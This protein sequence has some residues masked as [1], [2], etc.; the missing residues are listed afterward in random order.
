MQIINTSNY[1]TFLAETYIFFSG[2]EHA[3]QG[4][5]QYFPIRS[6]FFQVIA[7]ASH[8]P[9]KLKCPAGKAISIQSASWGRGEDKHCKLKGQQ[10]A[11]CTPIPVNLTCLPN[12]QVCETPLKSCGQ[13]VYGA[14]CSEETM[15]HTMYMHVKYDC[16]KGRLL[17]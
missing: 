5:C 9:V 15:A 17:M 13:F 10:L 14:P 4:Q 8:G 11:T 1:F 6:N 2:F 3:C 12:S 7:C 16:I